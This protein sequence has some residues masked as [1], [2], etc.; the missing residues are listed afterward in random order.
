MAVTRRASGSA[1]A[2]A[3][4]AAFFAHRYLA[5]DAGNVRCRFARVHNNR[6]AQHLFQV[7]DAALYEGLFALRVLKLRIF[8]QFAFT[9]SIVQASRDFLTAYRRQVF[10]FGFELLIPFRCQ[11]NGALTH[12]PVC[13]HN[14]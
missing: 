3:R 10:Q 14:S 12:V 8:D 7:E 9:Q 2:E 1:F 5:P 11:V 4:A 13:L 6:I